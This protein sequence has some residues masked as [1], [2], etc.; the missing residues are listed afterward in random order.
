MNVRTIIAEKASILEDLVRNSSLTTDEMVALV[1][2]AQHLFA[3]EIL[4]RDAPA[5]GDVRSTIS[6]FVAIGRDVFARLVDGTKFAVQKNRDTGEYYVEA[7][8]IEIYLEKGITVVYSKDAV[9]P[10]YNPPK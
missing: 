3:L 2:K 6:N 9:N 1:R 4:Y 10:V 7:D 5:E 8:G